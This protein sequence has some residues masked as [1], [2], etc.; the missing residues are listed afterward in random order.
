MSADLATTGW[1]QKF[2][3]LG[4]GVQDTTDYE[5]RAQHGLRRDLAK[6][7]LNLKS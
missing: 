4:Q 3:F 5:L 7:L 6:K 1:R 2:H